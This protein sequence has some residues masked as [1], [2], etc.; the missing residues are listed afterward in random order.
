MS[1]CC[2]NHISVIGTVAGGDTI[3]NP[4]RGGSFWNGLTGPASTGNVVMKGPGNPASNQDLLLGSGLVAGNCLRYPVYWRDNI[5]PYFISNPADNF[6]PNI[7]TFY[8]QQA[9][10]YYISC[11]LSGTVA[12]HAI[13]KTGL[14]PI[15]P[16]MWLLGGTPN[17]KLPINGTG[18]STAVSPINTSGSP[19]KPADPL[20]FLDSTIPIGSASI[21]GIYQFNV[22][23]TIQFAVDIFNV[24]FSQMPLEAPETKFFLNSGPPGGGGVPSFDFY[25]PQTGGTGAPGNSLTILKLA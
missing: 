10:S 19:V 15:Y 14:V 1:C 18:F 5:S 9:G 6:S 7:G 8:C 13:N 2:V 4:D 22:G 20:P 11:Q 3:T 25:D 17:L 16:V 23:D 21:S 12:G 24:N